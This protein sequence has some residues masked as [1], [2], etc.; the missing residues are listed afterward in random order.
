M[1][2]FRSIKQNIEESSGNTSTDNLAV[3]A[4]FTGTAESTLGI[5]G[6]QVYFE[7]DQNC[8]V[9][10][11]QG[12][13]ESDFA[14]IDSFTAYENAPQTRT[15]TSVAPYF[16]VKVTNIGTATTQSL[17]VTAAM[18]PII[19]VAPRA[20]S[21]LGNRQ[22]VSS[23]RGDENT[24]RHVWVNPT[25]EM[26]VSP[27]YRL[28]G[29]NFDG[30]VKDTNFWTDN[31]VN[32]GTVTQDG[33][34]VEL[35]TNT[36]SAG[37]AI[38]DSVRRGR[39][40][41]GSAM[42]FSGGFN[43]VTAGTANNVRRLGSY[44]V[45][46]GFFFQ[47]SGATFSIGARK[48]TADTLVSSGSFNGNIGSVWTPAADTYYNLS[49]E[50]TPMGAFYYVNS[51]LLHKQP[52]AHQSDTSTLPIRL[53]NTNGAITTDVAF[54]CVGAYIARQGELTT[55]SIY[56]YIATNTTTIC[57]YGAGVLNRIIVSDNLGSITVYDNTAASGKLITIL[58]TAQ[59][60]NPMGSVEF[61]SPFNIGLTI[62]TAGGVTPTIIYE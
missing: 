33:G 24:D 1:S 34:K 14:I 18:T 38:Y 17:V 9:A 54:D 52:G 42:I 22:T 26:S 30:S 43:F 23:I 61:S 13:T 62:V 36:T 7:A 32:G 15:F 44:D 16:R 58:D 27:V 48:V 2:F 53:E 11:E 56:K 59:G 51:R 57:K 25:N 47:L 8:T 41:A 20:L 3:A 39:F 40:V 5:N 21:N 50:Y 6:I 46:N 45:N 19:E 10:V 31:S 37:S 60:V 29:T 55:N 49:I 28:V 35:D 4:S 12:I